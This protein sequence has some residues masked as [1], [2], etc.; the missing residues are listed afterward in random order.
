[1]QCLWFRLEARG[2][3]VGAGCSGVVL[4]D[5]RVPEVL[6]REMVRLLLQHT[7]VGAMPTHQEVIETLCARVQTLT[8]RIAALER[9]REEA[10]ETAQF[11]LALAE[12]SMAWELT[13]PHSPAQAEETVERLRHLASLREKIAAWEKP[14]TEGQ[15]KPADA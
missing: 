8:A 10:R 15:E 5:I 3:V 6:E 9:E 7:G 14:P 12:R 13:V 4:A 2:K 1:M 11:L